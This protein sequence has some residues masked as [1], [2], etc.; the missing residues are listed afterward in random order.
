MLQQR[1]VE[2]ENQADGTL[3]ESQIRPQLSPMKWD[4][5]RFNEEQAERTFADGFEETGTEVRM[6]DDALGDDQLGEVVER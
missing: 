6:H 5:T 4:H 2:V 3:G 1:D